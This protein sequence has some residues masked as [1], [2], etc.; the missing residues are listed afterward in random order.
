MGNG[1]SDIGIAGIRVDSAKYIDVDELGNL[2]K[3]VDSKLFRMHEVF[4]G[5]G[6]EAVIPSMY[7]SLGSVAEFT[8]WRDLA[9]NFLQDQKLS[10]LK[11]FPFDGLLNSSSA[12]VFTD[13]HDTQRQTK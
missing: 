11:D 2:L 5:D 1:M 4:C 10:Y 9:S 13:N 3:R 6:A 12:V 7:T 8:Y